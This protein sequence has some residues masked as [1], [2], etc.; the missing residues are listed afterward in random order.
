MPPNRTKCPACGSAAAR[1]IRGDYHFSQSG[2]DYVYLV[3][4]AHVECPTC[5]DRVAAIPNQMRLLELIGLLVVAKGA[6]LDAR[7]LRYLRTLMDWTQEE[8]ARHVG[9]SRLTVTRWEQ[10]SPLDRH[11]DLFVRWA[12]FEAF[13]TRHQPGKAHASVAQLNA[14]R[15]A[16]VRLAPTLLEASHRPPKIRINVDGMAVLQEAA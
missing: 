13:S 5:D 14:A 1:T 2:L 9:V 10:G 15:N 8:M 12:W 4:V 11:A 6:P 3:G 7:D 16:L